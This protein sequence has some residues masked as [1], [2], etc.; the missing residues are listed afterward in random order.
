MPAKALEFAF[1]ACRSRTEAAA[2]TDPALQREVRKKTDLLITLCPMCALRGNSQ[3]CS[4]IDA[5][6]VWARLSMSFLRSRT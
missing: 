2:R 6:A 1:K 3:R 4:D 5:F